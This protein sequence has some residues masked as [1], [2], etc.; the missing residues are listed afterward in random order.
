MA[1]KKRYAKLD[2]IPEAQRALYRKE[3]TTFVL[4]LEQDD[5]GD[6]GSG[7]DGGRKLDEFRKTNRKLAAELKAR[8]ERIATMEKRL[9]VIGDSDDATVSTALK[10]LSQVQNEADQDLINAGRFDDVVAR[11]MKTREGEWSK[12]LEAEQAGRKKEQEA[13]VKARDRAASMLLERHLR[14]KITEKKLRLRPTAEE[15]LFLRAHRDFRMPEDLEGDP[16]SATEG[17]PDV[18]TW[19]DKLTT[20]RPHLWEGGAG[21]GTTSHGG[22]I[23]NGVRVVKR[24]DIP[25]NEYANVLAEQAAGKVK[26]VL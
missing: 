1:L 25:D 18:G 3:G 6:D 2:E 26:V 16:M 8:E 21:G 14:E 23:E 4:D 5:A 15:D 20:D 17:G 9:G 24:S 11:R 13:L 12:K 22:K 19:L 10:L 7:D